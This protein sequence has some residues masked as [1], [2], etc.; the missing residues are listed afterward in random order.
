MIEVGPLSTKEALV[1]TGDVGANLIQAAWDA[2]PTNLKDVEVV[3]LHKPRVHISCSKLDKMDKGEDFLCVIR[4]M[5][6]GIIVTSGGQYQVFKLEVVI[7]GAMNNSPFHQD[8]RTG[9]ESFERGAFRD[10]PGCPPNALRVLIDLG[11]TDDDHTSREMEF[12]VANAGQ[13]QKDM[14]LADFEGQ[15]TKTFLTA[16]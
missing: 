3:T 7:S 5:L 2:L 15:G 11:G 9:A 12:R 4:E 8:K 13:T 10:K 1:Y 16:S 14:N 6:H